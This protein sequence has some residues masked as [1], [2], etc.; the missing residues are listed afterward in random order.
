[1]RV[2]GDKKQRRIVPLKITG[3]RPERSGM[4][5]H[6]GVEALVPSAEGATCLRHRMSPAFGTNAST[7]RRAL[8]RHHLR[9]YVA[10]AIRARTYPSKNVAG[11]VNTHAQTMRST[12]VHFTPL[13]RFAAPTPMIEVEM[14]WVVESGMP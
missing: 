14:T 3:N 2:E 8:P 13:K 5:N 4:L 12:T 7:L 11:N 1:M 9:H 6:A 10:C